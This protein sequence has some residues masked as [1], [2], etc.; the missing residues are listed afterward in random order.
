[1]LVWKQMGSSIEKDSVMVEYE[2]KSL[3]C[4]RKEVT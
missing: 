3:L 1:M 2:H 4:W